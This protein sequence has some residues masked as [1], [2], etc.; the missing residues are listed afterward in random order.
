MKIYTKTGD[1]GTTGLFAG[2]RVD[3]DHPRIDAYGSVDEL[4]AVLGVVVSQLQHA[5]GA[6]IGKEDAASTTE[7]LWQFL[8]AVQ[9][10]LFAMGAELATPDPVKHEMCLLTVQRIEALEQFIDRL[11]ARLP[12]LESFILPGGCQPAAML[13]LGRTVCR[14]AE[15]RLV[16]LAHEP[17][18]HDCSRLVIYL[19]RLSDLLFVLARYVN[20]EMGVQEAVW[21]VQR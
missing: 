2:P 13:Q 15:R 11:D 1:C 6:S 9:S 14:R 5:S 16:H 17:G 3:K 19:N 7:E 18:V 4:N 10:D 21:Q 8:T 12:T 20:Q